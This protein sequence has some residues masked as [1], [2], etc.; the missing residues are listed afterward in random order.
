MP[1]SRA[2]GGFWKEI[3]GRLVELHEIEAGP[4]SALEAPVWDGL[5]ALERERFLRAWL[6][7]GGQRCLSPRSMHEGA[8]YSE[9]SRRDEVRESRPVERE[10]H[11]IREGLDVFEANLETLEKRIGSVL[12]A[13]PLAEPVRETTLEDRHSA[14]VGELESAWQRL[15]MLNWQLSQ[16]VDRVE[17]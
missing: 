10:L 6:D 9:P 15:G 4:Y 1:P 12:G 7:S 16:I 2:R 17:L 14:L 13:M 3:G 8:Q 11:R 5:Q